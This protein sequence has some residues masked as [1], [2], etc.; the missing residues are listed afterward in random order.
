[1]TRAPAAMDGG[2]FPLQ[3]YRGP[4]DFRRLRDD[5]VAFSGSPRKHPWD[6]G[7][8]ILISDPFSAGAC[9]YEFAVEAIACAEELPNIVNPEGESLAMARIWVKKGSLGIQ[10]FPFVVADTRHDR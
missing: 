4:K 6:P 2:H 7:R 9:Y 8:I 1:M 3:A 10:S 5:H